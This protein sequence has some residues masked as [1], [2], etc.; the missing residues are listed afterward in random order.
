MPTIVRQAKYIKSDVAKNNNKF[1]YIT[2]LDDASIETHW[3][4]VGDTGQRQ[5]KP[6]G[7]QGAASSFFDKKCT[8][9]ERSGRNGEIAYRPL[10]VVGSENTPTITTKTVTS[11]RIKEIAKKQ[12]KTNNPTVTKLIE[13]LSKVNAHN[14]TSA[15]QGQITYNDTTGQ[16][17]TPLGIV[18]QE[19]IDNANDILVEIGDLVAKG[20]YTTKMKNRTND[21]LMLVPQNIGRKRLEVRDFW[22]S[23]SVVQQQKAIVDSLQASLVSATSNPV[24]DKK[25]TVVEEKVFD[26]QLYLVEEGK[27]IDRVRRLYRKTKQNIHQSHNLDVKMVY[28]VDIN[29]VKESFQRVGS[30]MQNVWELW[31]GSRSS[32]VLSILKG[33]LIMPAKSSSNV[34]GRM[35]S[36]YPG[37]EGLYFSDQITKSLN[38]SSNYWSGGAKDNNCFMFLCSV[39]MGRHFTPSGPRNDLPR[40]GYDSTFAKAH[41]S[42]VY[43]NEMIVYSTSQVNLNYLIEFSPNGK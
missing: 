12:I 35:F 43:N 19:N 9:K 1:W 30:K 42:G 33:G 17:Q 14:I 27:A 34:T 11:S 24:S 10:N 4:R 36:G 29:S 6:F 3:G 37:K 15:T 16:F 8:E 26:C 13:Y 5:I 40:P 18:T 25:D 23:L 39:A 2:E 38:Y 32:N 21:Y 7:S 31:H 22:S 28:S 41:R 20:S